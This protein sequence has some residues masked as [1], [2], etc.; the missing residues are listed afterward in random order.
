MI[1]RRLHR[2]L[3]IAGTAVA[4]AVTAPVEAAS[5]TITVN[6]NGACTGDWQ[7]GG[8]AINPT[9][10]CV[11]SGSPSPQ[12][13][14]VPAPTRA[15]PRAPVPAPVASCSSG[16]INLGDLRFDGS[17][18]DSA[19]VTGATVAYARIVIP[20]PLP[21]WWIGRSSYVSVFESGTGTSAKR[22]Y[23]SKSP[24][25]LYPGYPAYSE[26]NGSGNIFMRFVDTSD[27]YSV[28]VQP[29][30]IWYLTVK[31]EWPSGKASCVGGNCNFA[32]RMY[33]PNN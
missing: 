31:N 2:G 6:D 21:G 5:F 17:Q 12:P 22:L 7:T 9:I 13:A 27:P 18:V 32:I 8:T 11:P 15:T 28:P 29:G 30:D 1:F 33:P 16:A 25:D 19:G 24:C 3:A 14:P 23:L 26:G 20:N 10:T 4:L